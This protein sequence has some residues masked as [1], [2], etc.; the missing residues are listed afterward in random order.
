M[1]AP[2]AVRSP[3]WGTSNRSAPRMAE[4]MP[5]NGEDAALDHVTVFACEPELPEDRCARRLRSE[6]AGEPCV[7]G[8]EKRLAQ[9][10]MI[11]DGSIRSAGVPS[12]MFGATAAL[13]TMSASIQIQ[14]VIGRD[15]LDPADQ[16]LLPA[17][18]TPC[19]DVT[20]VEGPID[21]QRGRSRSVERETCQLGAQKHDQSSRK[22]SPTT[23]VTMAD[24]PIR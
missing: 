13:M 10:W 14:G 23:I 8:C 4:V 15:S 24:L 20:G 6:S 7:S 12:R 16:R 18:T 11:P 1:A 19:R 22:R 17:E 3:V 21:D 5:G 9:Q 2:A